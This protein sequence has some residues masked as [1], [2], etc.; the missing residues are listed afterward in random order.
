MCDRKVTERPSSNFDANDERTNYKP[1]VTSS[2]RRIFTV[3]RMCRL[4]VQGTDYRAPRSL[5][6]VPSWQFTRIVLHHT[7]DIKTRNSA[8]IMQ[9][10][11][12]LERLEDIPKGYSEIKR[13]TELL[14][15]K[16]FMSYDRFSARDELQNLSV[17]P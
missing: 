4:N 11:L 9:N 7:G 2:P 15:D 16:I 1:P 6:S 12:Y 3:Y 17:I 8:H 10:V 13:V 5:I 14:N